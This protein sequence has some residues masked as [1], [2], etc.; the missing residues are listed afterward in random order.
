VS[1]K[2]PSTVSAAGAYLEV[3][4][5]PG[6]ARPAAG[7]AVASVPIGALSLAML[8]LV[9]AST[10]RY[11]VAGLVVGALALGTGCGILAQ[12]RLMDR[13]GQSRV[14]I[15]AVL[16]QFPSLLVFVL[17]LRAAGPSWLPAV[18]AFAAG[19]CEPQVGGALR[20]LWPDLTP[21]RLRQTAIAWSSVIL[22]AS[23]L[24]GPLLLVPA[25]AVAGAAGAVLCCGGCF[26][27]GA[28]LL[29]T[30]GPARVWHAGP[31]DDVGV[32]GALA[33]PGV[34]LLTAVTAAVGAV[35]G[36]TQF[37]AAALAN[38]FGAP[39]R[40]TWLFAALSAGSLIGALGYGARNWHGS[41]GRRL[42]VMLGCLSAATAGCTA[43]PGLA[44]LGLG[45]F[46]CGLLLGPVTV[47]CFSIVAG[48]IPSGT[49]VGGFTTLTAASLAANATAVATAGV[50]TE[51]AGSTATLL[52]AAAVALAGVPLVLAP[53]TLSSGLSSPTVSGA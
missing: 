12:G 33:S 39:Q 42:A 6:V 17:A 14:L 31:R 40:A 19:S 2:I 29:A 10:G 15:T 52:I 28:V 53:R 41:P 30:S 4:R 11:A 5:L 44:Y 45:L 49:E 43:A 7:V 37:S 46:F 13:F 23:V 9:E 47:A 27:V 48:H 3:L 18:L 35:A 8:L 1:G 21:V 22:E 24:A 38:T 16:V 36:F 34:R 51:A 50:V 25:L 26:A 32:L 20:A